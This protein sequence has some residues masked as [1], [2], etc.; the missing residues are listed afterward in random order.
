MTAHINTTSVELVTI[1]TSVV[2]GMGVTDEA[3]ATLRAEYAGLD[4]TDSTSHKAV[5]EAHRRRLPRE[6][7]AAADEGDAEKGG[8]AQRKARVGHAEARPAGKLHDAAWRH[9]HIDPRQ[10]SKSDR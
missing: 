9:G 5:V 1:D 10:H 3:L 2:P 6:V 8:R 4:A 7:A